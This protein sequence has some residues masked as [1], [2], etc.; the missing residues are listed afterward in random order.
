MPRCAGGYGTLPGVHGGDRVKQKR[1]KF[2]A[3]YFGG[4]SKVAP[5][6]W[7]RFGDVDNFIEPFVGSGAVLLARP[8]S[9]RI[10]TINDLDCYVCNVWRSLKYD[11]DGVAVW[12]DDVVSEADLHA[13]HRWLVGVERPEPVVPGRFADDPLAREAYLAGFLGEE[14][15]YAAA[16]RRKVRTDPHY[17]DVKL[18]GWYLWGMC[19]W[20]GGGWCAT[21]E[22]G[23]VNGPIGGSG[24]RRPKI[25]EGVHHGNGVHARGECPHEWQ[26]VPHL[27]DEGR[28]VAA[29]GPGLSQQRPALGG[30]NHSVTHL[31]N[32]VHGRPQL[33]DARSR[34]RGVHGTDAADRYLGQF[35]KAPRPTGNNKGGNHDGVL[36]EVG[37]GTCAS[38]RAWLID[39]FGRLRDRLRTVRVCCGDWKRVCDSESVTVRLGVTGI[40]FD[41][42]YSAEADRT[43]ALYAQ[44][45]GTVAHDVRA[46]CLERGADPR[47]RIVLCGYEGEGHDVLTEH[48]WDIVAWKAQGGYSNRNKGNKNKGRERLWFSPGCVKPDLGLFAGLA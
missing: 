48:G 16:F 23:A 24:E 1:L 10:E 31:G 25:D 22:A 44:D 46:Y 34:G 7:N 6:V 12:A 47:Y 2:P 43:T 13:R 8:S 28:G 36:A 41:P 19:A 3:P 29:A 21:P 37:G 9:P 5:L 11:P 20:I 33:A 32:G 42:P 17:Y 38:R 15:T 45:S 30:T 26:Q 39:W 35:P 27:G 14:R 18:A 4:K 40:F